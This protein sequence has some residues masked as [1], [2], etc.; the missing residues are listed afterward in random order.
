MEVGTQFV[1]EKVKTLREKLAFDRLVMRQ[2]KSVIIHHQNNSVVDAAFIIFFVY[3]PDQEKV[4]SLR[5]IFSF[6]RCAITEFY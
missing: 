6:N 2:Y 4:K 3:L 1:Q 5:E